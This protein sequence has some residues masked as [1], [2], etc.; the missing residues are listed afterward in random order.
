MA[1][2]PD[3]VEAVN[4]AQRRATL[5]TLGQAAAEVK[6]EKDAAPPGRRETAGVGLRQATGPALKPTQQEPEVQQK[7]RDSRRKVDEVV[8]ARR[9]AV[10][11]KLDAARAQAGRKTQRIQSFT[12]VRS[13]SEGDGPE[14]D[15]DFEV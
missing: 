2:D 15:D 13:G 14:L 1:K 5:R 8:T 12:P 4:P 10:W 6:K 11:D 9:Q 3:S 7:R